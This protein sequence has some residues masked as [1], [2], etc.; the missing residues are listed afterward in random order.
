L[1]AGAIGIT[2]GAI[3][4]LAGETV[5][6]T[7]ILR[8]EG[9]GGTGGRGIQIS[10]RVLIVSQIAIAF[11]LLIGAGLLLA[12]F[13]RG[14]AIDPGFDTDGVLTASVNLPPRYTDHHGIEQFATEAV[15]AIRTLPG[16]VA[17]GVTT[18]IP[19]GDDF[20]QDVLLPEGYGMTPG[21]SLIAPYA[22]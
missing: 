7:A 3:P 21:E 8:Q 9:R 14:V 2:L 11:V 10:R 16:V 12:S 1:T 22:S 6:V 18:S 19:F 20:S 17:V 13:R 4:L 5:S 15:G